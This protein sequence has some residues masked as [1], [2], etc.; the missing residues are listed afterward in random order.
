MQEILKSSILK[1]FS[2]LC[3]GNRSTTLRNTAGNITKNTLKKLTN[4][5]MKHNYINISYNYYLK[6]QPILNSICL[7]RNQFGIIYL[8]WYPEHFPKLQILMMTP[9]VKQKTGNLPLLELPFQ[10][11]AVKEKVQYSVIIILGPSQ[12]RQTVIDNLK[13]I[14]LDFHY[15]KPFRS[16]T[17]KITG[18]FQLSS[19]L[20][21]EFP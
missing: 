21:L 9:A 18:S 20:F 14:H 8:P 12:I 16:T 3:P 5:K 4:S 10:T 11:F 17:H 13:Y 15:N 2:N 19:Y 7:I 6:C 1:L